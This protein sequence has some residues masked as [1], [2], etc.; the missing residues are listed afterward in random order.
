MNNKLA[1][2]EGDKREEYY[3]DRV[4]QHGQRY[5]Q[6]HLPSVQV[7]LD[8]AYT[9]DV[10]ATHLARTVSGH[11]LSLS[12][13]N[14]LM[15]LSRS[16]SKQCPL[17]EI[18][19]LL[20]VSRANVTGLV[21]CLE[22]KGLVE[23]LVDEHDRRVRMARITRA[24]EALLRSLL[25]RHYSEL[26]RICS[27]L[28]NTEKSTLSDLLTKL[29]HSVQCSLEGKRLRKKTKKGELSHG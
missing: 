20:L 8:L 4:R 18:G 3:R 12:A 17:H 19:E 22:R 7:V 26:K 25:P 23:R 2:P 29:R 13:F 16:V 27:R 15:I 9:Y 1:R 5:Q 28:S 14:V 24:G 6:F 11:E 10:A 21:D